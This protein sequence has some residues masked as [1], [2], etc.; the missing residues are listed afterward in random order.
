MS[1]LG[2]STPA[3]SAA[4]DGR[5]SHCVPE[6]CTIM[7]LPSERLQLGQRMRNSRLLAGAAI[8][9]IVVFASIVLNR[10]IFPEDGG[11]DGEYTHQ[12]DIWTEPKDVEY[13]LHITF[14]ETHSEAENSGEHFISV[15]FSIG[16]DD[17]NQHILYLYNIPRSLT[18]VWVSIYCSY[19]SGIDTDAVV[20][21]LALGILE[22]IT[23]DD[24]EIRLKL[25]LM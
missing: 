20:E 18:S 17:D 1:E 15:G 25:T 23:L 16:P 10:S 24:F 22:S 9:I 3:E 8:V 13:D 19:G 14:Y 21:D 11:F 12:L 6:V 7:T 2:S 5:D 4:D